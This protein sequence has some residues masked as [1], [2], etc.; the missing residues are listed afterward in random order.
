MQQ[1]RPRWAPRVAQSLIRRLYEA[2]ARGV[3][4]DELIDEVGIAL[5]AR[6][7]SI[8]K[9]TEAHRGR[10]ECPSCREVLVFNDREHWKRR[11]EPMTCPRCDWS[12]TW[13]CY[14]A[15][16]QHKQ[17]HAGSAE[18]AF[19][20]FVARYP[21]A[22]SPRE[23]MLAID[24]LLHEFHVHYQFGLTRPAAANV[25]EGNVKQVLEFL[26]DLASTETMPSRKAAWRAR[27]EKSAFGRVLRR[28]AT[29]GE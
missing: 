29:E 11:Q 4:D 12:A 24:W 20:G 19:S 17:L 10:V 25:I 6:C 15:T 22:R 1:A 13:A 7:E 8:L 5:Y 27:A 28:Q 9:V 21:L 16:F 26:D 2:D 3:V 14:L 18:H 23:K